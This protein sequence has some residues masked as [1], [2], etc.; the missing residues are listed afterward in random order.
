METKNELKLGLSAAITA[1]GSKTGLAKCLSITVQAV[2]QWSHKGAVPI[3]RALEIERQTGVPRHVLR[4]DY[5]P[6]DTRQSQ[7]AEATTA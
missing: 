6:P 4:P 3:E 5:Y 1:A 2:S 7:V